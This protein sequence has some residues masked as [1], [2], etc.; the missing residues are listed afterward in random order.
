MKLICIRSQWMQVTLLDD[1]YKVLGTGW[2]G[3]K[4]NNELLTLYALLS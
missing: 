3:W 2:I 1:S 4:K